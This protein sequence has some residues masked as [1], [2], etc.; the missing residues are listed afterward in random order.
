[1]YP[2]STVARPRQSKRPRPRVQ[3]QIE[4]DM[5]LMLRSLA[6][7]PRGFEQGHLLKER[8][9][10]STIGSRARSKG[11]MPKQ[12]RIHKVHELAYAVLFR[13]H[14]Q[15]I[16]VGPHGGFFVRDATKIGI[17]AGRSGH[18][19]VHNAASTPAA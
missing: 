16:N 13:I 11:H 9:L 7:N 12:I 3:L 8:G 2:L 10:A 19:P 4:I 5:I 15:G 1:M 18:K 17:A 14:V 6:S